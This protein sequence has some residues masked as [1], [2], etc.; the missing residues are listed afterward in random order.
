M[1]RAIISILFAL[2]TCFHLYAG[3]PRLD[4]ALLSVANKAMPGE[5]TRNQLIRALDAGLWN[6][7]RTAVAISVSRQHLK[8]SVV[9]VFLRQPDG[10]YLAADASRVEVGNFGKLGLLPRTDY[11]R[12]ETIPVEWLHR[13][14]GLFQVRIRTRAWRAGQR[15]TVYEP[16]IIQPDGTVLYR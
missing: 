14:D 8:D 16:L 5:I 11:E 13:D 7:D 3:E 9:V 12:F 1:S 4:D 6:S 2:T 15:Y 10:S